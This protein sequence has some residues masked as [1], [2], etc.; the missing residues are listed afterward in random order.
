MN[1]RGF[2]KGNVAWNKGLK[3]IRL[4]PATEFKKG[5]T[6]GE[7]HPSWKGGIQKFKNDCTYI[8]DGIN[9]RIRRP[10]KVYEDAHGKIPKNW[11]LYHLDKNKDND[12]LNN[13]VAIPRAIL[14]M[15]NS[16]RL[17]SN[18]YEINEAVINYLKK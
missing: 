8:Y 4:S 15:L 1:K 12:E 17:N 6:F 10:K 7:N 13:L 2:K 5:E 14:V 16:G 18:Y 11:V 9:K 3:G